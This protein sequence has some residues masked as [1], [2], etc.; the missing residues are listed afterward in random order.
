M[1]VQ[2]DFYQSYLLRMWCVQNGGKPAWQ[3]SLESVQT[4]KIR[5]FATIDE[6]LDF[7]REVT[8]PPPGSQ[9]GTVDTTNVD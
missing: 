6:L 7:I 1:S 4:G 3:A 2:D 5:G 8:I 9:S